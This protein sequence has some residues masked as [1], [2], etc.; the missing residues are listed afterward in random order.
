MNGAMS[1]RKLFCQISHIDR[2]KGETF[3]VDVDVEGEK[4]EAHG[5]LWGLCRGS[6]LQST[7]HDRTLGTCTA[8]EQNLGFL[9]R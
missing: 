3:D 6:D 9:E 8:S 4:N 7:K 5:C 2:M 1:L